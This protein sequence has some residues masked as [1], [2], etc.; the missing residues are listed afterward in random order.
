MPDSSAIIGPTATG[1]DGDFEATLLV[2]PD[3]CIDELVKVLNSAE[4]EILL[5]LQYLD[6]D[7]SWGWGDNPIVEALE[8]AAQRDA[9]LRL[10]LNG[11]YLDEEH[12]KRRT[13]STKNGTSPWATTPQPS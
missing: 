4:T 10:I 12:P 3:N 13:D 11:A 2:C 8:N 5:S 7:W 1:I 6:M 9:R